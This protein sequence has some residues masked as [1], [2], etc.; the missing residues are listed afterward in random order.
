VLEAPLR[1]SPSGKV[2]LGSSA[3]NVNYQAYLLERIVRW[4]AARDAAANP[5]TQIQNQNLSSI[6]ICLKERYDW[7]WGV[8]HD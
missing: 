5:E 8:D 1:W 4:N 6:D 7:Y 3:G 2:H